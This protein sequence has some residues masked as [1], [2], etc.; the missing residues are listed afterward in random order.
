M[1]ENESVIAKMREQAERIFH[2]ALRAVDPEKAILNHLS[3]TDG[4]IMVGE[5]RLLLKDCKRIFVVGAGKA[6]AP[7]AQA[8]EQVLGQLI[9]GGLII[10]KEGHGLPLEYINLREASHPVPDKRGIDGA[11]EIISLVSEAG[12]KDLVICLIS[13]GGSALL[14]AP[15]EGLTLDDKQKVTQLL[16]DC[17]ATI[18]EINT[19]RKHLSRV[20][21]GG[22]ARLAHPASVVTLVLS[23]VI[24]DD[25]DVIASGPTVPDSSTFEQAKKV[26]MR[27]GVWESVPDSV[28]EHVDSGV[29]GEIEETSKPGDPA[30]QNDSWELV[31]NNLKALQAARREAERQGYHTIIL[32][33]M[34]EGETTE[35]AKVHAAIAKEVFHSGNPHPPPLCV[36][37]GGETTVTIRGNGK[38]GRNQEFALA[39]ALEIE[40]DDHMIVLSGGSDGTDGPTNAAGAVADGWTAARGRARGMD[41]LDYLQRNDS[42]PFF[43]AIGGL[44]MTGPTR[45]N[46]MD[47]RVMLVGY[48]TR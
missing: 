28:R 20:K 19:V 23:D 15:A 45:T 11:E 10:V 12:E 36:L 47:V 8:V 3:L 46:V 16:L 38:G 34:I 42:Y 48:K 7:M 43:E 9:S 5:R 1:D 25:L 44:L 17:G 4:V 37:S 39:A 14:V 27:Y 31:G 24:G 18:H 26:L 6:G 33:G 29:R 13:G 41:P 32:S 22:L 21:G 40:G 30:F 35:V 2:A